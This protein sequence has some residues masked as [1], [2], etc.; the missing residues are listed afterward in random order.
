M[1]LKTT[2]CGGIRTNR[3]PFST[4]RNDASQTDIMSP[5]VEA[6]MQ[7]SLRF[8]VVALALVLLSCGLWANVEGK[9]ETKGA[10]VAQ[11]FR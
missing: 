11:A 3:R 5:K 4:V 8:G 2:I 7:N 6:P 9:S 1:R 10:W